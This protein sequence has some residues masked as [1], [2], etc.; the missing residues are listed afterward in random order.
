[1]VD[2]PEAEN[3]QSGRTAGWNAGEVSGRVVA[4]IAPMLGVQPSMDTTLDRQLVPVELR[5]QLN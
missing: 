1:M 5:A 2:E 3:A 4:R